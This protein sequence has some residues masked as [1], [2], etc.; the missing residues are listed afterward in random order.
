MVDSVGSTVVTDVLRNF[1]CAIFFVAAVL[2]LLCF[3]G[4]PLLRVGL[5]S[6]CGAQ[7]ASAAEHGLLGCRLD[8]VVPGLSCC[9]GL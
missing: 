2:G 6:S 9:T 7:L 8:S 1:L 3:V 5:F 4:S